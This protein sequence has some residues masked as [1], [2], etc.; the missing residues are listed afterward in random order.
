MK[1]F[2]KNI[3]KYNI[4]LFKISDKYERHKHFLV[5]MVRKFFWYKFD[6]TFNRIDF[7]NKWIKKYWYNK[8]TIKWIFDKGIK[9]NKFILKEYTKRDKK[10]YVLKSN[11]DKEKFNIFIEIDNEILKKI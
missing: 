2:S 11:R 10:Y 6:W 4:E 7:I 3:T 1:D 5:F 8:N 9:D